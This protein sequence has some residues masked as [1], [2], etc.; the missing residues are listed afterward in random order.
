MAACSTAR[1]CVEGVAGGVESESVV[2]DAAGLFSAGAG[3]GRGGGPGGRAEAVRG[4]PAV[5]WADG[6]RARAVARA[7]PS[8]EPLPAVVWRMSPADFCF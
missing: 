8:L 6:R 4:R 3:M 5:A 2:A 1:A 7:R